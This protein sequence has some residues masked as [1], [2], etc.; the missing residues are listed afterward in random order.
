MS[1][2]PAKREL[3]L[4]RLPPPTPRQKAELAALE[5]TADDS[6]CGDIPPLSDDFWRR[7]ATRNPLYR[8]TQS[9]ITVRIDTDV[10]LWLKAQGR[11]YQ[12]RFNAILREAMLE[13]LREP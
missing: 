13:E 7:A 2:K 4:D 6:D 12:T 3:A 8:P 9:S 5:A 10:P 11:G 1:G